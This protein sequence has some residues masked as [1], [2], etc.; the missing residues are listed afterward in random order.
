[1]NSRAPVVTLELLDTTPERRI[2]RGHVKVTNHGEHTA[3]FVGYD[4][5]TP[6]YSLEQHIGGEWRDQQAL[7]CGTGLGNRALPAKTSIV[8]E[9]WG[10]VDEQASTRVG[11]E[12]SS[13]R[14][15]NDSRGAV[16]TAWSEP[17]DPAV[18]PM[19]NR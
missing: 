8:W 15:R 2:L 17:F 9:W 16:A 14:H 19:L 13:M 5:N 10:W 7:H 1:M 3:W 11:V 4:E 12:F 6:L 18:E